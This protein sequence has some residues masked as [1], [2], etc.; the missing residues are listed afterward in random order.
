MTERDPLLDFV[1]TVSG[2]AH[3]KVEEDLGEGFV[4]LRIS[5]AERRQAKHD[6]R[7]RTSSS[8]CSATAA[9][10]TRPGCSSPLTARRSAG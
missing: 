1:E 6:I 2:E 10:L 7:S 8:S 3:L 9:T 5:E 4:R